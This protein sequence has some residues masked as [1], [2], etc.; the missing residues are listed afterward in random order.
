MNSPHKTL[1][2]RAAT[3]PDKLRGRT[4]A[5]RLY[6]PRPQECPACHG[7]GK[8]RP[9]PLKF[10]DYEFVCNLCDG[11]GQVFHN[12]REKQEEERMAK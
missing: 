9:N 6:I 3:L 1:T 8:L 10:P 11:A 4:N 12:P 7:T 2:E 5:P